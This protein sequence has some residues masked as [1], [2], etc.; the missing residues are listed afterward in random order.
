MGRRTRVLAF[1][2]CALL[3]LAGGAC[4]AAVPG[5]AGEV[6]VIALVSAGLAGAALLV[7]LEIG[8]AEDRDRE[9]ERKRRARRRGG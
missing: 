8:L 7:F 9:E 4:G 5:L 6:L 3:V 2:A 1:G